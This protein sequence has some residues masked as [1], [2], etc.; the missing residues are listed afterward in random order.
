MQMQLLKP[1]LL[2]K[3][4]LLSKLGRR[5]SNLWSEQKKKYSGA[6]SWDDMKKGFAPI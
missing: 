1:S 5:L 3:I 6:H 4:F 2:E